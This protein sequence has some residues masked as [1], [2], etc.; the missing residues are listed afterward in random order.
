L[1]DEDALRE[2]EGLD[3]STPLVFHCHHGGRSQQAAERFLRAGFR[4]V[5]NL[6]GGI[7]AW[8]QQVDGSVPRY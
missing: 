5:Y 7:D 2:I 6:S 8:S 4:E 3:H 1:L